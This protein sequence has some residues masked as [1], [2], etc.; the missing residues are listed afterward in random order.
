MF[1]AAVIVFFSAAAASLC[2]VIRNFFACFVPC[3]VSFVEC[4]YVSVIA[5]TLL[6]F[7]RYV[8]FGTLIL[9]HKKKR[10]REEKTA[11]THTQTRLKTKTNE[12][13]AIMSFSLGWHILHSAKAL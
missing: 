8:A 5:I 1:H 12:N 2:V 9:N 4:V 3:S 7:H 10:S 11:Q 13:K 6:A